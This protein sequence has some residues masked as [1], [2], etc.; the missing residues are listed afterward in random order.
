M[1]SYLHQSTFQPVR[2]GESQNNSTTT[3]LPTTASCAAKDRP[4]S[5]LT[6][7]HWLPALPVTEVGNVRRWCASTPLKKP[8]AS[9]PFEKKLNFQKHLLDH[10]NPGHSHVS[11]RPR[12]N[13]TTRATRTLRRRVRRF[14]APVAFTRT[15]RSAACTGRTA[16]RSTTPSGTR[17]RASA[18]TRSWHL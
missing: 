7:A 16:M 12:R 13:R 8:A 15:T 2:V 5:T 17:W 14:A 1:Q 11:R 3:T 9:A 18:R 10:R 4:V 6:Y